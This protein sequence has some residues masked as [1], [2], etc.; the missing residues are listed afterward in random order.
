MERSF[1][2]LLL[3]QL[4]TYEAQGAEL[5]EFLEKYKTAIEKYTMAG[6][7]GGWDHCDIVTEYYQEGDSLEMVPQLVMELKKLQ[8]SEKSAE[9]SGNFLLLW[10]LAKEWYH[11]Y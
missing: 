4:L 2:I 11:I 7:G 10:L 3:L 5:S 6:Y 8:P 9:S 1:F